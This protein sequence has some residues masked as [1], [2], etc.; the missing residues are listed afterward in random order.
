MT[1]TTAAAPKPSVIAR[2]KRR[3]HASSNG[4]VH[5]IANMTTTFIM[6]TM[7]TVDTNTMSMTTKIATTIGITITDLLAHD[8]TSGLDALDDLDAVSPHGQKTI[9][10]PFLRSRP[11]RAPTA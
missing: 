5:G 1:L 11:V 4:P 8:L 3:G 7:T 10:E 2:R 9:A 6:S